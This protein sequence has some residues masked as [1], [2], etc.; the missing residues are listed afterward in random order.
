MS[1][2]TRRLALRPWE[3]TD[4][5]RL[6]ELA[7]NPAVGQA[8]GWPPHSSAEESLRVIREVFSAP[9]T[10]AIILKEENA[11]CGSINIMNSENSNVELAEGEGEIGF[12]LGAPYWGRGYMTEALAEILRYGFEERGLSRLWCAYFEGSGRS[13]RVQEKRGFKFH[14]TERDI[15]WKLTGDVRTMHVCLLEKGDWLAASKADG[16]GP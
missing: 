3:E 11:P 7:S 10:F 1:L 12:W 6:H 5:E 15:F 14:H 8:A 16:R 2:E 13:K 4:A 9:D